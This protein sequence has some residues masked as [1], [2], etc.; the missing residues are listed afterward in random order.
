M[1]EVQKYRKLIDNINS[2]PEALLLSNGSLLKYNGNEIVIESTNENTSKTNEVLVYA[3][4]ANKKS[5]MDLVIDPDADITFVH[6]DLVYIVKDNTLFIH[7]TIEYIIAGYQKRERPVREELTG[8]ATLSDDVVFQ[9][10]TLYPEFDLVV[11]FIYEFSGNKSF[12]GMDRIQPEV[13]DYIMDYIE[14]NINV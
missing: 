9:L 12:M 10:S 14:K 2:L 3:Q 5:S 7:D 11:Q 6:N 8:F 1:T 4:K 13:L